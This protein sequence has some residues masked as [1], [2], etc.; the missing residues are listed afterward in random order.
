MEYDVLRGG[1]AGRALDRP[2][3]LPSPGGQAV[4]ATGFAADGSIIGWINGQLGAYRW[5]PD[6]TATPLAL[7][8]GASGARVTA[9][10]GYRAVGVALEGTPP[11]DDNS[12]TGVS[13]D[14]RT[15]AATPMALP[16]GVPA[17][18]YPNINAVNPGGDMLYSVKGVGVLVRDRRAV[19]LSAPGGGQSDPVA[20]DD[21]G[22]ILA[23]SRRVLRRR[24]AHDQ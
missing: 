17:A 23:G 16:D 21:T 2:R 10:G 18:P 3:V 20:I 7:P 8:A 11:S 5:A 12:P 4:S 24:P 1:V 6:G 14:L 9:V 22:R 13:W 19:R 15:G